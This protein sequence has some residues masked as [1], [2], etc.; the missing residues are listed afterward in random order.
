MSRPACRTSPS[1]TRQGGVGQPAARSRR[2]GR[3]FTVAAGVLAL[4]MMASA[5]IVLAQEAA[6]PA[7]A[8]AQP[9]PAPTSPAQQEQPAPAQAAPQQQPP[10]AGVPQQAQPPQAEAQPPAAQPQA[11]EQVLVVLGDSLSAGYNLPGDKAFP[12]VLEKA[13]R[14]RGHNVKVVNAGVSGDTTTGGLERL[15]W[16]VPDNASGVIVELGANDMLRGVD[17]AIPRDALDKIITR[18]KARGIPVLLAGMRAAPNLGGR[19]SDDFE[20]IYQ[21]LAKR[22]NLALYPFFLDGVAGERNLLLP[23]GMHPNPVG[24]QMMVSRILPTVEQFLASLT[25]R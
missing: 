4:A 5:N 7:P 24:V 22:H 21:D 25:P 9:V 18:L 17:P 16:S 23:D 12:A 3:R 6:S 1:M 13:L 8:S 10:N 20:S 19:Y 15:D 11:K 2:A 14:V